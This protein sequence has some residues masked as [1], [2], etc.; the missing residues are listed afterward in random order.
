MPVV[1]NPQLLRISHAVLKSVA[2]AQVESRRPKE[3]AIPQINEEPLTKADV[4]G[5]AIAQHFC[6]L[7]ETLQA[8]MLLP[9]AYI[10]CI[11][12]SAD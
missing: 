4:F 1:L 5:P 8:A 2:G 6:V 7:W 11:R 12:Q 3:R 10:C 9:W